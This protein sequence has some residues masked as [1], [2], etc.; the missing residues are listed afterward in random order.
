MGETE[1][2]VEGGK[3]ARRSQLQTSLCRSQS[4]RNNRRLKP[5]TVLLVFLL[6]DRTHIIL[7]ILFI[8]PMGN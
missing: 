3:K 8:N 2:E 7:L 6:N 1:T 4:H 5:L